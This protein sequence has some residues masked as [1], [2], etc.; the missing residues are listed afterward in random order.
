LSSRSTSAAS[1]ALDQRAAF[2][3]DDEVQIGKLICGVVAGCGFGVRQFTNAIPFLAAVKASPPDL[4]VLDLALG[5]SDAVEVIRYLEVIKYGG[6]VLLVSGRDEATLM[7]ISQIGKRHGLTMLLPLKKP[8]R[9]QDFHSRLAASGSNALSGELPESRVEQPETGPGRNNPI[10]V[11]EALRNNWLQLWYQPKIELKSLSVCGAEALLRARHPEHGIL[12]PADI[13]PPPGDPLYHPLS[14]FVVERAL[15]D[16]A[17]FAGRQLPLMLA[18]N[19]PVSVI[20]APDFLGLVRSLLPREASFPGLIIEVTEDEMI[21]DPEWVREIA[22]QLKLYDV[23]MSVDDFGSGYAS[24]SRLHDLP[25]IEVKIDRCF[26]SN[27][28]SDGLKRGLCQTAI[29]VAHRFGASVCAEGVETAEDLRALID[30]GCDTAQGFLFARP[31]AADD[32]IR[33]L[34]AQPDLSAQVQL[35]MTADGE[36]RLAVVAS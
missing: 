18:V 10:D 15:S 34:L 22:T 32:L 27:C 1:G 16:W 12:R 21:R 24:L 5:Q 19:M 9:A 4:V 8:F 6:Q 35:A 31:M 30:M 17:V 3:L 14:R 2:V 36:P 25:F 26:V 23:W 29:D 20:A 7:E 33:M 28:S 11:G 13:L